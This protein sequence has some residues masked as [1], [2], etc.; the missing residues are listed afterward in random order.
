MMLQ[1]YLSALQGLTFAHWSAVFLLILQFILHSRAPLVKSINAYNLTLLTL[2]LQD[3]GQLQHLQVKQEINYN[4]TACKLTKK[5]SLNSGGGG[6]LRQYFGS[7]IPSTVS[8]TSM[9]QGFCLCSE[10]ALS[11]WH[12]QMTVF[13]G[14]IDKRSMR[15][16]VQ[17]PELCNSL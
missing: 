5:E 4:K 2:Y 10:Q 1:E 12:E 3:Y 9:T 8:V 13:S 16:V 15:R 17:G 11:P 14:H 7:K 6:R